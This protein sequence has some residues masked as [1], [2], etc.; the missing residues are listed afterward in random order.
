[1]SIYIEKIAQISIQSPLSD[2]WMRDPIYPTQRHCRF[3]CPD[4]KQFLS[5]ATSRRMGTLLKCALTSAFNCVKEENRTQLDGIFTGSGLGCIENTEKFLTSMLENNEQSLSPTNFIQST[6]NTIGSQ[7]AIAFQC[8]GYNITFSHRGLSFDSALMNALLK[9][10]LN[11]IHSALVN[12]SDEMSDAYFKLFDHTGYWKKSI[13]TT[14]DFKH[15]ISSGSFAG[16]NSVSFLLTD[17]KAEHTLCE[18]GDIE[19]FHTPSDKELIDRTTRFLS[20]YQLTLND[21]D[22]VVLGHNG[23]VENDEEYNRI[24]NLLVPHARK[25]IYKHIFG[26]S[27]TMSAMGVYVGATC[28]NQQHI[29]SHLLLQ[30]GSTGHHKPT[31]IL[32]VNHFKKI[33]YSITLLRSC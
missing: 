24:S 33:D 10:K 22:T 18:I 4:F 28:I 1:M 32:V 9:F 20:S 12:A 30:E 16:E 25:V 2:E 13:C 19:L 7:I 15:A 29:P 31:N 26:E 21:I 17:K 23:D 6:H 27:F 8:H 3:I 5:P 11:E 14:D